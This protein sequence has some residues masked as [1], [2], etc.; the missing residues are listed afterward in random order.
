MHVGQGNYLGGWGGGGFTVEGYYSEEGPFP[1][2]QEPIISN[3]K[4]CV[5]FGAQ[6]A[7]TSTSTTTLKPMSASASTL[8]YYRPRAAA[9]QE[10][11]KTQ[12]QMQN[13]AL[14]LVCAPLAC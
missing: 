7:Q 13:L 11:S 14:Q 5:I 2:T 10:G 9:K 8:S 4:V 1:V 12:Q 3:V 6:I